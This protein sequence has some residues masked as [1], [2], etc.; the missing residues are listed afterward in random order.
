M[1]EALKKGGEEQSKGPERA[2]PAVSLAAGGSLSCN[3]TSVCCSGP[4]VAG[5]NVGF[6]QQCCPSSSQLLAI[7]TK[8]HRLELRCG[9]EALGSIPR[10]YTLALIHTQSGTLPT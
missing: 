6:G 1:L 2:G 7:L 9:L 5:N 8:V 4:A 10:G 3:V